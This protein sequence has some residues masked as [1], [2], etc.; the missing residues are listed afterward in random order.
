VDPGH[1]LNTKLT[2]FINKLSVGY[3][4]K[5]GVRSLEFNGKMKLSFI[6]IKKTAGKFL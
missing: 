1:T 6:R 4:Q 3:D 5:K 2:G